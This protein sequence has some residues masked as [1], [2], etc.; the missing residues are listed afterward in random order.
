MDEQV[1]IDE[2]APMNPLPRAMAMRH[3]RAISADL[4][5]KVQR[6][7]ELAEVYEAGVEFAIVSGVLKTA[8]EVTNYV[9]VRL[10]RKP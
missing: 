1:T 8:L 3:L 9:G 10:E 7:E 6:L 2:K 5:G 4:Q